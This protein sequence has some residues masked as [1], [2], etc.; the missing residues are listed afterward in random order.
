MFQIRI[1]KTFCT[2]FFV[3]TFISSPRQQ[4]IDRE[5]PIQPN[6]TLEIARWI[7]EAEITERAHISRRIANICDSDK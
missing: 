3:C 5:T 7:K 2:F 6:L 4:H 1:F